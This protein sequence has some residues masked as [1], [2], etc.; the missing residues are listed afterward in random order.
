M[1]DWRQYDVTSARTS[2]TPEPG[3]RVAPAYVA[4]SAYHAC[5][6]GTTPPK[7]VEATATCACVSACCA[8]DEAGRERRASRTNRSPPT[9]SEIK[10]SGR[11]SERLICQISAMPTGSVSDRAPAADPR[12][13]SRLRGHDA[14]RGADAAAAAF[15]A[16]AASVE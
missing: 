8:T 13:G 12:C 14:L 15:R 3:G 1:S 5:S 10:S 6:T 7:F 16:R 9:A 2:T 4:F 11:P